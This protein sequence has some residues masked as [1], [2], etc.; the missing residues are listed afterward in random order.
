MEVN[1]KLILASKVYNEDIVQRALISNIPF[2][3]S[4]I[5]NIFTSKWTSYYQDRLEIFTTCVKEQFDQIDEDKVDFTFFDS[6]AFFDLI[7]TL[8][9]KSVKT[10]H[11]EK[12]EL[13]SKLLR[14][15]VDKEFVSNYQPD[16]FTYIINEFTP[17]ELVLIKAIEKLNLNFELEKTK[18]E[19]QRTVYDYINIKNL[20]AHVD[21]SD[22]EI[23]FSL[24]K[25]S[26]L[27][28]LDEHYAGSVLGMAE[29]GDYKVTDSYN[30]L[31]KII[32]K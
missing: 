6:E 8:I 28:L 20:S 29:G 4:A 31:L 19:D 27:G 15:Q 9:E 7:I 1:N 3:G 24:S 32:K 10:R 16:D 23:R 11:R 30:E 21:Y 22:N 2:I 5:D 14:C 26:R 12:I 18:A 17:R 25:L 13:F